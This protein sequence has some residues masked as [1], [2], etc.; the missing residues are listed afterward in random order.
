[1]MVLPDAQDLPIDEEAWHRACLAASEKRVDDAD[2]LAVQTVL[3]QAKRWDGVYILSVM[4]ALETSVLID[5]DDKVFIDWGTAGQVTLQPP[6]GGRLPFK[7]WVHTHPRFASYW[8]NTDTN[9][10]ALGATIL[11]SAMVLGQPGPKSSSNRGF[12][13]VDNN[14]MIR[15]NGPLNQWT[16][17]APVPWSDWYLNNDIALEEAQ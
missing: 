15:E 12:V 17:E 9:S 1:M 11:E 8:S 16:E 6:V 14:S 5:A 3:A 4:A 13:E 2:L 10:L 7:L